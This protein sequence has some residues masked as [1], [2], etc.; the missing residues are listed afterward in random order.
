MP[1]REVTLWH[2]AINQVSGAIA[3]RGYTAALAEEELND[4]ADSLAAV[5]R[6]MRLEAKRMRPV[7]KKKVTRRRK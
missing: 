2:H 1:G 3:L 5:A 6:E 7:A 4:W